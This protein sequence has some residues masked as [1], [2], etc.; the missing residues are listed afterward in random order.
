MKRHLKTLT[1]A[2]ALSVTAVASFAQSA[3]W[4]RPRPAD[5]TAAHESMA[6]QAIVALRR[7]S[8][9]NLG[10][11]VREGMAG[12]NWDWRRGSNRTHPVNN[13]A[14]ADYQRMIQ[15]RYFVQRSLNR[16]TWNVSYFS[17]D[18]RA[19]TC[20][21][22]TATGNRYD[23]SVMYYW[24]RPSVIGLS[25]WLTEREPVLREH[26]DYAWPSVGDPY[27]GNLVNYAWEGSNWVGIDGFLQEDYAPVFAE[28]CPRLPRVS[29]VNEG[30]TAS[31]FNT[32]SAQ[33]RKFRGFQVAFRSDTANPL[34]AEMLYWR[35]AP[36]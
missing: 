35:H 21:T 29:R 33:A 27:T 34:T 1:I 13:I 15:G 12:I 31:D 16:K 32:F 4:E 25:G 23:E 30:Q 18:G 6:D 19:Y 14:A 3:P 28:K 8:P 5:M 24:V 9:Q 2:I 11:N 20:S 10:V 7:A 17:N 26:W 22:R 36:R